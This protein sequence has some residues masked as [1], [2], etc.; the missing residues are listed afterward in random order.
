MRARRPQERA[1]RSRLQP[2]DKRNPPLPPRLLDRLV[3]RLSEMD[4]AVEP[5]LADELEPGAARVLPV[6][7][8][9]AGFP[10]VSEPR[11]PGEPVVVRGAMVGD[12]APASGR[13]V[14]ER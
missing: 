8:V 14:N 1:S 3:N 12:H 11:L 7:V 4:G 2:P 5:A 9:E 6:Q 13:R 10:A